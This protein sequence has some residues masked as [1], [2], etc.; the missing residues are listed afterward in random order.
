MTNRMT[1]TKKL[2]FSAMMV[3]AGI[4]LPMAFHSVNRAGQIFAPMHLPVMLAGF[5]CG[6]YYGAIVG[7]I[8][9]LL[10][11]IF[12]GMPGAAMLPNMMVELLCYGAVSGLIFRLVRTKYF[13]LDVYIALIVGMLVGRIMGGLTSYLLFVSGRQDA[14][15][16]WGAFF[17]GYFVTCL[18]AIAIQVVIMPT[19]VGV[20]KKFHFIRED[21]RY[22]D[23]RHS[24]KRAK[25]QREFF[26]GLA[27]SWREGSALDNDA[28]L[29]LTQG[30][31]LREGSAVLDAA[32]GAGV[33]DSFLVG[34][35]CKVDAI[36]ISPAMIDMAKAGD[37]SNSVNYS[38][39]DF[40]SYESAHKYD[41]ILVFDAYP[42]FTDKASFADK[43]SE[44]LNEG[45]E[46]WI[47]FDAGRAQINS[48]HSPQ[49]DGLSV[50][51]RSAKTEARE[52]GWRFEIIELTDTENF[53]RIGLRKKTKKQSNTRP[54][55]SSN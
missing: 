46:L 9:P 15:Y 3:A 49:S 40:Y 45:G 4:L 33:L 38:V 31:N 13:M 47:F 30:M 17:T 44:L 29:K 19:L 53:Y 12:T 23:P 51:L 24:E 41:T 18:P 37:S 28:I 25:R 42:H 7:L 39:A 52:L 43:A 14:A 5:I 2:V 8:C 21:D 54:E 10:S 6:P 11:F 20:A 16:S 26:D 36:D 27:P 1:N 22:L 32:C 34:K 50:E 35:G 48:H 55:T